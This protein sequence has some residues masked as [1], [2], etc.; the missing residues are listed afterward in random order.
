MKQHVVAGPHR[1]CQTSLRLCE[2]PQLVPNGFTPQL[3]LVPHSRLSHP[4]MRDHHAAWTSIAGKIECTNTDSANVEP[5]F[6]TCLPIVL[7]QSAKQNHQDPAA[8]RSS[9]PGNCNTGTKSRCTLHS[10][11]DTS[12]SCRYWDTNLASLASINV[13]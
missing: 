6:E 9:S 5:C 4:G 8:Q 3:F 1:I 13:K 11:F 10:H 2:S 12:E 7:H